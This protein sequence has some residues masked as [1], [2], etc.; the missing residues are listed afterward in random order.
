MALSARSIIATILILGSIALGYFVVWPKWND[1]S[2][3]KAELNTSLAKQDQLKQAQEKMTN[4][5]SE[6]KQHSADA[7]RLQQALPLSSNE[8]HNILNNFDTLTKSSGLT[9]G[10]LSVEDSLQADQL[11]ASAYSIQP[12]DLSISGEG[13]YDAFK[14]FLSGLESNLRIVD[15]NSVTMNGEDASMKFNLKFRTYYQN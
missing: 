7:A 13:T 4:F 12:I 6:Y 1:Y 11:G 10:E 15:I 9:L 5:L 14:N 8:M 3:A 2:V